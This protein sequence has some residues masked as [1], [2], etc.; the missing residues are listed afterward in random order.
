MTE[1]ATPPVKTAPVRAMGYYLVVQRPPRQSETSG[2][3]VLPP[4]IT[5]PIFYG[6]VLS[7]GSKVTI[8]VK[9]GDIVACQRAGADPI[10]FESLVKDARVK[11]EDTLLVIED[12]IGMVIDED[13][14]RERGL[15]IDEI[16][17]P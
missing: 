1:T 9:K 2:G 11:S 17:M 4:T 14:A 8:E 6:R 15:R 5:Q 13:E 7:V 12:S 16:Q 10:E 3:I